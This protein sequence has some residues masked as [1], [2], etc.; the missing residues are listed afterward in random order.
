MTN[1]SIKLLQPVP[2]T[3][4]PVAAPVFAAAA[5]GA[6]SVSALLDP[7]MA[8]YP[9]VAPRTITVLPE[10][11]PLLSPATDLRVTRRVGQDG[12][13]VAWLPSPDQECAGYLVS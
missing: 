13:V 1:E 12:L 4:V 9:K 8:P 2:A 3:P 5:A 10:Q 7:T 11:D 6:A